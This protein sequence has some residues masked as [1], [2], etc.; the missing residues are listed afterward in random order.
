M[1]SRREFSLGLLAAAGCRSSGFGEESFGDVRRRLERELLDDVVP[2]WERHSLDPECGGFLTCLNRD[3][4]VYDTY[5]QMWMQW[6]EV[7]MFAALYNS[8]Y[9]EPRWLE[10]AEAGFDFL[11]RHG[12]Q[13]D[14]SY[15]YMLDRRGNVTALA[16]DGGFEVFNESFAA[17]ACAELYLATGKAAYRDEAKG[18]YAVYTRK[19]AAAEAAAPAFPAKV[20]Y[21][22]L[23][24]PMIALNVAM[25]MNRA[26]GG[27]DR[28]V[29]DCIARMRTFD[30][31]AT[32]L[33]HERRLPDGSFDHD[34]QDGRFINP[35]HTLEGLS[36]VMA[37]LRE[38]PDA[39]LLRFALEK[40]RKMG[41]FGWDDEQGGVWYFRDE[42][43]LPLAKNDAPLKAWWPQAEAMTAMLRAY[44][45]SHD[46]WYLDYF[47]KTDRYVTE[48][49]RDPRGSEWFAYK[50]VDGR[51]FHS[52]KGSRFKGFFHIPRALLDSIAVLRRLETALQGRRGLSPGGSLDT[53]S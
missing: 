3:G 11:Y 13:K 19:T 36:F 25:V 45:L 6:R 16:G 24:Y 18:A 33:V 53:V 51:R 29:A 46:S 37:H 35:G 34:T 32:G 28:E 8:P 40:T 30:D 9:R 47:R 42:R 39:D 50:T 44:E 52:Y 21:R 7:W 43:D 41:T 26:F 49:L 12:R 27:M 2:F 23:A 10:I 17:V 48:N 15:A 1:I 38:K 4:S 22:Q 14:G 5:K 20:V 31:P